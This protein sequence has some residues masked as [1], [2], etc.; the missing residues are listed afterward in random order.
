MDRNSMMNQATK[1][2]DAVIKFFKLLFI[3]ECIV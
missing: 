1:S 3:T 2:S